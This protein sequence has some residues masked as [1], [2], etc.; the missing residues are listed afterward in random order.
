VLLNDDTSMRVLALNKAQ[1]R[2]AGGGQERT[3]VFTSGIVSLAPG[4]Q[5]A[6][7]FTGRQHVGENLADVLR[8]RSAHLH[9]PIQMC[10]ALSR[11]LPKPPKD[12]RGS[13]FSSF[14][15]PVRRGN[16]EFPGRVPLRFGKFPYI[17]CE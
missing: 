4:K 17:L 7:F 1:A 9:A 5:I 8:Q 14:A 10:D 6:L 3:G 13:L 12:H 15:P 2:A 11:N 16:A